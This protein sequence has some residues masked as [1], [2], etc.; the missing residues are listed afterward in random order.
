MLL[1]IL[2][3]AKIFAWCGFCGLKIWTKASFHKYLWEG[4]TV[5]SLEQLLTAA[6]ISR[7]Y[8]IGSKG[9]KQIWKVK[10]LKS[11]IGELFL[12]E[13]TQKAQ[14]VFRTKYVHYEGSYVDGKFWDCRLV[15]QTYKNTNG[16]FLHNRLRVWDWEH[17]LCFPVC[18]DLPCEGAILL[19]R[20]AHCKV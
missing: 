4:E 10:H 18:P 16:H 13:K 5:G 7:R 8:N 3:K 14:T 19:D 12:G 20:G 6:N 2:L 17:V 15:G 1:S 9:E 11:K